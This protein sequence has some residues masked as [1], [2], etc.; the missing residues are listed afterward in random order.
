MTIIKKIALGLVDQDFL[1]LLK[2]KYN[3]KPRVKTVGSLREAGNIVHDLVYS[4]VLNNKT[5]DTWT[6]LSSVFPNRQQAK[7]TLKVMCNGRTH[8]YRKIDKNLRTPRQRAPYYINKDYPYYEDNQR[9][10]ALAKLVE[11]WWATKKQYH[12]LKSHNDYFR[13]RGITAYEYQK[14]LLQD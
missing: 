14:E 7:R 12:G 10:L 13:Q 2:E 6:S 11:K 5:I 9:F 3:Y 8:T 1:Q 4:Q